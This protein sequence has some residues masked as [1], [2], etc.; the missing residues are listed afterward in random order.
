ML[1]LL[2]PISKAEFEFS[3]IPWCPFS[4]LWSERLGAAL[5]TTTVWIEFKRLLRALLGQRNGVGPDLELRNWPVL[6]KHSVGWS[7]GLVW[8][9][10]TNYRGWFRIGLVS[11]S[12]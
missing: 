4:T 10:S 1:L 11:L 3:A 7:S 12:M 6:S 2:V 8:L 9:L 5:P